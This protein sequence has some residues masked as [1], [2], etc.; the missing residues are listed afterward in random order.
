MKRTRPNGFLDACCRP[1]READDFDPESKTLNDLDVTELLK[2]SSVGVLMLIIAQVVTRI[3]WELASIIPGFALYDGAPSTYSAYTHLGW[4]LVID[5]LSIAVGLPAV[6]F[7]LNYASDSGILERGA[8]RTIT[9]LRI[10]MVVLA[11]T[12][13]A[14]IV[15]A[16]FTI[17]ELFVCDSTLC[18]QNQWALIIFVIILFMRAIFHG[19]N[20]YRVWVFR[21]T[22]RLALAF[23]RVDLSLSGPPSSAAATGAPVQTQLLAMRVP[24]RNRVRSVK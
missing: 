7:A 24:P 11:F 21:T 22:L 3:L 2:L 20:I 15:H 16:G 1:A 8:D 18:T 17:S 5:T 12:M 19:W 23:N 6:Y 9:W 13:I 14:D 10:Y 4:W